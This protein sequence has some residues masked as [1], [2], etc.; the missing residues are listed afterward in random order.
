[1]EQIRIVKRDSEVLRGIRRCLFGSGLL[2]VTLLFSGCA[3]WNTSADLVFVPATGSIKGIY[4][5]GKFVWNDLLTD[6]VSSAKD[7]YGQLFGWTFETSG[8]YT[9]IKNN[10]QN[11]GRIVHVKGDDQ[12]P[13]VSRWLC[14]LSVD[15]I[16]KAIKITLEAG[17]IVNEGPMELGKRGRGALVRDPQGAQLMLLHSKNGDPEDEEPPLGSWLWHELWSNHINESLAF[18]QKLVG[19]DFEGEPEDYL[20]LSRDEHW[21]AGIRLVEH[22]E[23]EMRWVPVVRVADTEVVA[24]RANQLGGKVLIEPRP[25]QDGGSVALLSDQANALFIIQQ[26]TAPTPGKE[27]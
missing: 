12:N 17:G 14:V 6:N 21:R 25:T 1:M 2:L 7:F 23:H 5:P 20:I 16:D 22:S 19:Y 3:G 27:D 26:W 18:Y 13:S 4:Y 15:D 24:E 11:I 10:G 9:V 8:K